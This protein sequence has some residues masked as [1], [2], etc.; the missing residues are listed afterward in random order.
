MLRKMESHYASKYLAFNLNANSTETGFDKVKPSQ[1][2]NFL[3]PFKKIQIHLRATW[4]RLGFL[5]ES[6][7]F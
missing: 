7:T 6:N 5:K 2:E 4:G 1:L 3:E